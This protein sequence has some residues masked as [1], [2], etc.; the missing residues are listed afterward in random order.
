MAGRCPMAS[1]IIAKVKGDDDMTRRGNI[2]FIHYTATER[3][4]CL[5]AHGVRGVES[6]IDINH[7]NINMDPT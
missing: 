1:Q 3:S 6:Q 5:F 2:I 7:N 4:L